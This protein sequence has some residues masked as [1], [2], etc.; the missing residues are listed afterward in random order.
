MYKNL[1]GKEE[2]K[3]TITLTESQV[4]VYNGKMALNP[5]IWINHLNEVY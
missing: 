5:Q 3:K 2:I 4:I 1:N